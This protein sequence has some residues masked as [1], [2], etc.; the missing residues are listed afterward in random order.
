MSCIVG[1]GWGAHFQ[2]SWSSFSL[3]NKVGLSA[4]EKEKKKKRLMGK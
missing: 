3:E 1:W 4:T 2:R